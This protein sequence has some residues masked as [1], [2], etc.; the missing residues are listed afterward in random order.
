MSL[1]EF[2]NGTPTNAVEVNE[3]FDSFKIVE[4]YSGTDLDFD[5]SGSDNFNTQTD[6]TFTFSS[7]NLKKANYL[8]IEIIGR[9]R[10]RI[11]TRDDNWS[12]HCT[13]N[14]KLTKN[15]LGTSV[16]LLNQIISE[17]RSSGVYDREG[18]TTDNTHPMKYYLELTDDDKTN[19]I[20]VNIEFSLSE[21]GANPQAS[22]TNSQIVFTL[23]G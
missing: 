21:S 13:I 16:I 6:K 9:A 23:K 8:V 18:E 17:A 14:L 12:K 7:A 22:F 20:S 2:T 3:N 11:H 10:T 1:N 15:P 5:L 19:G 4:I